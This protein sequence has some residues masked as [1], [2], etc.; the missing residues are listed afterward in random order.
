MGVTTADTV[1]RTSHGDIKSRLYQSAG[2]DEAKPIVVYRHGGGW[3]IA[4]LDV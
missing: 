4:D 2:G 3:I 1:I